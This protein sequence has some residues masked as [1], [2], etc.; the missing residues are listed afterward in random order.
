M[1]VISKSIL[2]A[3]YMN[4]EPSASAMEPQ[5][6]REQP[7]VRA[8]IEDGHRS[9]PGGILSSLAIVGRATVVTPLSSVEMA[10][11]RVTEAMMAVVRDFEVTVSTLS[12]LCKEEASRS[13]ASLEILLPRALLVR[14]KEDALLA[15]ASGG[16]MAVSSICV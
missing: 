7:V 9:N 14:R 5:S 1:G 10:V 6:R 11:M 13:L 16:W 12:R 3:R 4:L 8:W 15:T 2:P